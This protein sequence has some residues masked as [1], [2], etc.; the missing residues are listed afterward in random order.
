MSM[1]FNLFIQVDTQDWQ[2]RAA[3]KYQKQGRT[4]D[5]G[6]L[7]FCVLNKLNRLTQMDENYRNPASGDSSINS[8]EMTPPMTKT[9]H[10]IKKKSAD[11]DDDDNMTEDEVAVMVRNALRKARRAMHNSSPLN[12]P[13]ASDDDEG[14]DQWSDAEQY[15]TPIRKKKVE[16]VVKNTTTTPIRGTSGGLTDILIDED[17]DLAKRIEAEINS[18]RAF[19]EHA[20]FGK[21]AIESSKSKEQLPMSPANAP[22]VK[23]DVTEIH[24]NKT[25]SKTP[26]SPSQG[27]NSNLSP[28]ARRKAARKS[29]ASS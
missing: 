25:T 14:E 27:Y 26:T 23:S 4:K 17:D 1:S 7:L 21:A 11:D 5:N 9:T 29:T 16:A 28:R 22:S 24:T 18:A 19:A 6:I 3:A 12:T 20:Y 10:N 8:G 15:S 13:N 2:H